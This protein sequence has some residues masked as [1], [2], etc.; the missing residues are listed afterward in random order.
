MSVGAVSGKGAPD[1]VNVLIEVSQNSCPVKYE[2]D[3]DTGILCVDRFLPTAMYYPCNYGYVPNTMAGDGDPVDVLVLSRFP[4]ISGAVIRS[5][6]VGVLSMHDEK[7]EDLKVL[8][9]PASGVD[10]YY[11]DVRNYTDLPSVFLDSIAHFFTYYKKL[12]K[13]KFVSVGDW[14][15]AARA[16]SVIQES[17]VTLQ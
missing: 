17:I 1:E 12:E 6:P 10:P 3:K 11:E 9:V 7:G 4:V 5:R 15:D 8:A 14:Q 16:R 2:V 13:E